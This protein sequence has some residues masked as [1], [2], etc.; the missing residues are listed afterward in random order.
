M[1]WAERAE[2]IFWILVIV[3]LAS[4]WVMDVI[5]ADDKRKDKDANSTD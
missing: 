1:T 4:S 3:L 5:L 2:W